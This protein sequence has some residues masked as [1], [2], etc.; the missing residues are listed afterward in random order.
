[1]QN[2]L[3]VSV[4]TVVMVLVVLFFYIKKKKRRGNVLRKIS[5][6]EQNYIATLQTKKTKEDRI[7]FI[8]QCN[9]EL[10]R[11]IFFTKA[12]ADALIQRLIQL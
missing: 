6:I 7:L 12:E 11:N 5:D 9:S 10:A 2:I 3:I 1:M 8:K 4:I